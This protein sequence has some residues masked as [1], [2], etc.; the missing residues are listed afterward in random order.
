MIDEVTAVNRRFYEAHEARDLVAMA[1][2]WEHSDLAT[3][4]HP[5]W[6]IL[7]G[8]PAVERSWAAIFAGPGRNQFVLTNERVDVEGTLAWVTVDEN[9]IDQAASGTIA[10]TNL[11]RRHDDGWRLVLHHGSPV[12]GPRPDDG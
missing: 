2:V 3:C 12:L 10:A 7:R 4:I 1:A 5:G 8:W 11:Y 6:A 9:L